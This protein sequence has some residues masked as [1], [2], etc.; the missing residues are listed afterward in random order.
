MENKNIIL[1]AFAVFSI[2]IL[3]CQNNIDK[4]FAV[5]FHDVTLSGTAIRNAHYV[6]G[7]DRFVTFSDT[8]TVNYI[9]PS[10]FGVTSSSLTTPS[11]SKV[12]AG[13]DCSSTFCYT[14]SYRPISNGA[15]YLIK[16]SSAGAIV[17]NFTVGNNVDDTLDVFG[18]QDNHLRVLGNNIFIVFACDSGKRVIDE[19]NESGLPVLRVGA[20]DGTAI[21]SPSTVEDMFI[22]GTKM[23]LT[24]NQATNNFQIWNLGASR[25]CQGT[26]AT[27]TGTNGRIQKFGSS[28][29]VTAPST[30]KLDQ[31][32]SACA[33]TGDVTSAQ[34][35]LT[36]SSIVGF[37]YSSS[38][39]EYYVVDSAQIAVMNASVPTTRI[40]L[41]STQSITT[42][43]EAFT[44][45]SEFD[46]IG[47]GGTC[48]VSDSFKII[49][50]EPTAPEEEPSTAFC[51][52]PAN[53]DILICRNGGN[54]EIGSAGAFI[55]GNITQGT[56]ILGIGCSIGLVD[57]TEDDN[58]QTNGLGLLIFI[59]S[60]FVVVG[61]FYY[62]GG[63]RMPLFIWA[64]IIISLSA[65]F[66]ITGLI[67]PIFLILSII[68]IIAL[69]APKIINYVRGGS[70]GGGSTE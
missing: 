2:V 70:F 63:L 58:P 51:D 3:L 55:M 21:V 18:G 60:I 23:V 43:N 32:S 40:A 20:C 64:I 61:M 16:I 29:Y 5:V 42:C 41:Y 48:S 44:F 67:N 50:L 31:V 37:Q 52:D 10:T 8:V 19:Y 12:Y 11:T 24:T 34:T 45:S 27:Y 38:R 25:V 15:A 62:S 4:A 30:G 68:A 46:Q 14:L 47:Y 66:T 35:G 33:D 6:S 49:E 39:G 59:A 9:N 36:A 57:C 54:G 1:I 7:W 13:F 56:G 28:Y 53:A 65:F 26:I 22:D 69:T 17:G